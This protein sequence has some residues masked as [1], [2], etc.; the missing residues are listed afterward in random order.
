MLVFSD[1]GRTMGLVVDEIV[2]IVED[3]LL[4]EVE[5][6]E[7]GLLGSAVI[8]GKATE[9]VDIGHY[10]LMAFDD[11]FTREDTSDEKKARKLLYVDD[12]E[13]FQN[14]LKPILQAAGYRVTGAT[15]VEE[16]KELLEENHLFDVVVAD[17]EMSGPNGFDLA[18]IIHA[19]PTYGCPALL[20]IS[21]VCT[22]SLIEKCRD[23]RFDDFVAKF[24][25]PGLISALK[26]LSSELELAA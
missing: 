13:F 25:R 23:M 2:D 4:I 5:S 10:L 19:K 3:K 7:L 18:K 15:S 20:A 11:W 12:S 8:K 17:V 6:D 26:E 9:M 22:P 21:S 16:A 24:D 1:A 14:M